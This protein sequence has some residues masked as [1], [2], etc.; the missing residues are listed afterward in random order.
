VDVSIATLTG[1]TAGCIGLYSFVPQV[2]KCCRTSDVSA[3]S[4]RMFA[5]RIVGL[6]LR[7][8][9]SYA[10]GSLPVLIF[11]A[12]G[13]VLSTVI[14][15]LKFLGL[16]LQTAGESCPQDGREQRASGTAEPDVT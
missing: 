10:L 6:L 13:L 7:T 2:V 8:A 16:R 15:I 5:T 1:C 3:I 4:L 9:Y 11:R 14:L 12:F